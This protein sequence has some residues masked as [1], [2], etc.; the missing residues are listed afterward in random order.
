MLFA[1]Y[2]PD[3]IK[4][5]ATLPSTTNQLKGDVNAVIK[6]VLDHTGD[7]PRHI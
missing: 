4:V 6:R 7:C 1:F 3:V 5:D 2:G